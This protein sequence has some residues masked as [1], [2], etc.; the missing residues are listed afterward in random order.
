MSL[1][2]EAAALL[3]QDIERLKISVDYYETPAKW[4]AG[5]GLSLPC[6]CNHIAWAWGASIAEAVEG[7]L[8]EASGLSCPCEAET[9][10]APA[11]QTPP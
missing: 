7:C 2:P 8:S 9:G 1:L 4:A 6:G 3:L 11:P 5:M 10:E